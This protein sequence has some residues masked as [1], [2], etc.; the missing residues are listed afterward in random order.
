MT[1]QNASH[2]TGT[3][4]SSP[5]TPE[6][7]LP[8]GERAVRT[9]EA[10]LDASRRLFL[11]RGY[12]GTRISNITDA[13]GIS[14]A[15]FYTY[16]RDKREVFN[17][18]G[19]ETYKEIVSVVSRWSDMPSPAS[20]TDVISWVR[21]YFAFMD[22][23][24]AFIFSSTQSAPT[25]DEF[26]RNSQRTQTRVAWLLG[27]NLVLRQERRYDAPEALGLTMMAMLDQ[28][29]YYSRVWQLPV[30]DDDMIRTLGEQIHDSLANGR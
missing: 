16:F 8:L 18:I 2:S 29:Y 10:I 27:T 30:D 20:L 28:S 11:E 12:A 14:R 3:T 17:T 9:R 22:E 25:D 7:A 1:S 23:H 19:E 4:G 15:G 26:R 5:T 13:C 6:H 24:G 21:E